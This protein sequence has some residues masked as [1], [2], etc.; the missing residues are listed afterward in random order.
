MRRLTLATAGTLTILCLAMSVQAQTSGS[1]VPDVV[2]GHKAGM[3]LTFDVFSPPGQPN[4]A[5]VL[6]MVSGGWVSRW[7]DPEEAQAGY[8]AL[9]DAGFTVLSI[10]HGS[11][12]RF[13]VPEAY[14][15]V[16][17]AVRFVRL[18][19]VRFGI[20]PERLGVYGGSAG[21]HLSLMLGLASDEGDPAADDEVLRVSSR[22]AAVVAYYPPVDLRKRA[23]ASES[24]PATLPNDGLFFARGLV[25]G[26]ADRFVALEFEEDLGASISPILHVS[27]DD[28]P[29]L[30]VHGDADALVD[31]NN[32]QL[33]HEAFVSSGVETGL[34]VIKGA[35]HGFRTDEER[36]QASD[37]LVGWFQEHLTGH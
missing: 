33:I 30:L 22:V 29:T 2:Y 12:P 3:A 31:L 4:G 21:G 9:L 10:R 17:R 35:G 36:A 28:P 14:A 19:A 26:A 27:S 15:D 37:A 8:Q 11:S 1:I 13:N 7:R 18:H 25:P 5:A 6:N 20:D 16:N 32:S 34:V 24:F 23:R